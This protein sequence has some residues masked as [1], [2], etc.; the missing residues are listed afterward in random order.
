MVETFS[1]S[2]QLVTIALEDVR[3]ER[4]LLALPPEP[5]LPQRFSEALP[6]AHVLY[7]DYAVYRADKESAVYARQDDAHLWF[8]PH[9]PPDAGLHDMAVVYLPKS[10]DEIAFCFAA[11]SQALAPG[12]RVMIVGPKKS[13][14]RSSK[15]VMEQYIGPV[16]SA[17]PGRHCVLVEAHKG[18]TTATFEGVK[19]HQVEAFGHPLEVVSLPGVFS[20]GRLD[21]GTRFLL[22]NLDPARVTSVLD[23]GCGA[24]VIG[25]ALQIACPEASVDLVDSH[26]LAIESA[27]RTLEANGL[28]AERVFPSDV[29]SDV[30]GTYDLIVSNPPFHQGLRADFGVPRRFIVEAGSHLTRRGRLVIVAGASLNFFPHLDRCFRKVRVLAQTKRFRVIEARNPKTS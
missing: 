2:T 25:T 15:P 17:R 21:E 13:A 8:S 1:G 10:T 16:G 3:A 11:L 18:D 29:F 20:H 23:W 5:G 24:G 9:C 30:R 14:I 4:A 28:R 26:V 12:A 7:H 27:R 6:G 19:T 22:E